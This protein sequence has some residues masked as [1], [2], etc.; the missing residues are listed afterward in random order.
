MPFNVNPAYFFLSFQKWTIPAQMSDIH[1]TLVLS[2]LFSAVEN[3][4]TPRY[5]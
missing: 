4:L 3:A 1:F 5:S 2:F